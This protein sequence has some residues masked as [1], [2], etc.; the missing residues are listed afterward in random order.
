MG[1]STVGDVMVTRPRTLPADASVAAVRAA[2]ADDHVHLVLLVA[3]GILV[4]TVDRDDLARTAV[5]DDV[6][7]VRV[8]RLVGR[9]IRPDV[10]LDVACGRL[11]AGRSPAPRRGRAG[12][13]AGRAAVPQARRVRLLLR[14]G[15]RRPC[16]RRSDRGRVTPVGGPHPDGENPPVVDLDD[17]AR[18]VGEDL[19][20]RACAHA[21]ARAPECGRGRG[22]DPDPE[23][24]A[25]PHELA[26][27]VEG[28]LGAATAL[29]R[30][31][32]CYANLMYVGHW[33]PR[34]ALLAELRALLDEPD[35]AAAV[36]A[37]YWLWCGPFEGD[38]AESTDAWTAMV[39]KPTDRRLGRLLDASGPVP[40]S[41]KGPLLESLAA[42]PR[43]HPAITRALRAA[44]DDV[45]GRVD[46]RAAD[47]LWSR[48]GAAT[49]RRRDP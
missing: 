18:S 44:V 24:A 17:L 42:D 30:A 6:V 35:D 32:P 14:R 36:P 31:M 49:D 29:Y 22:P 23:L 37:T 38:E 19:F 4:S 1:A 5:A 48:V 40:W 11:A 15:G 46:A 41:A 20:R 28:D 25:V 27:L 9:T 47:R 26:D 8:G 43:W 13:G 34:P 2:L 21:V 16:S 45:F 7:A 3:D 12:R 39:A 10:A 33:A